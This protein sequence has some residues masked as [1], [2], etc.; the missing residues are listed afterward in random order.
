MQGGGGRINADVA[1]VRD[2]IIAGNTRPHTGFDLEQAE[3]FM[4]AKRQRREQG[5]LF[6][7]GQN[8]ALSRR[9]KELE[10]RA[11]DNAK[12]AGRYFRKG[13]AGRESMRAFYNMAQDD[14]EALQAMLDYARGELR[15]AAVKTDGTLDPAKLARFQKDHA[16]ALEMLPEM[17]MEAQRLSMAARG[18]AGRESGLKTVARKTGDVWKLNRGVDVTGDAG[19]RF[20]VDGMGTFTGQE[21]EALD[22]VQRDMA[23]AARADSLAAVKGSPTAQNLATQ[24]ILDAF[25]GGDFWKHNP[26]EAG[27]FWRNAASVPLNAWGDWLGKWLYGGSADAINQLL[28]NAMLD[29]AEAARLMG[30]RQY[31]PKRSIGEIFG[32]SGRA[33]GNVALRNLANTYGGLLGEFAQS[34]RE[35]R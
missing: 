14:P 11:V 5:R 24:A 33:A 2:Q 19:R 21:L 30:K 18:L 34:D 8:L 29:P 28:I 1:K 16:A 9:G 13:P 32:N 26:Q 7:Q 10:G 17:Q 27:G 22:A 15:R 25:V 4:A 6:E 3:A 12:I 31:V 35:R 23:R 20:G